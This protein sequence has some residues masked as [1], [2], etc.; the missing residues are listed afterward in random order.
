MAHGTL[1]N[2]TA[3]EIAGG[4]TLV[5]GTAYGIDKGRTL[6][7]GTAYAIGFAQMCSIAIQGNPDINPNMA[8]V[9]FNNLEEYDYDPVRVCGDGQA[10]LVYTG[11]DAEE[12]LVD[13]S[14]LNP[15]FSVPYGLSMYCYVKQS[16]EPGYVMVNGTK[17]A[18]TTSGDIFYRYTII[19]HA[20]ITLNRLGQGRY[21]SVEITEE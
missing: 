16:S 20:T 15:T 9:Q 19:N 1:I 14:L 4:R 21:G 10:Y 17:V 3:Y 5:G 7:N 2:G 18:E 13:L 12:Q 11:A 8:F 6:V